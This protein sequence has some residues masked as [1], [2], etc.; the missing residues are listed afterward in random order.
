MHHNPNETRLR[1][2]HGVLSGDHGAFNYLYRYECLYNAPSIAVV[3]VVSLNVALR[4]Q[5]LT[6]QLL[7]TLYRWSVRHMLVEFLAILLLTYLQFADRNL[8]LWALSAAVV[9]FVGASIPT[10]CLSNATGWRVNFAIQ[11]LVSIVRVIVLFYVIYALS[12]SLPETDVTGVRICLLAVVIL[13]TCSLVPLFNISERRRWLLSMR[14][15]DENLRS[16]KFNANKARE[17]NTEIHKMQLTTTG[18]AIKG[19]M[20]CHDSCYMRYSLQGFVCVCVSD[21]LFIY[22][23]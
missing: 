7:S 2:F 4:N 8:T 16:S 14:P 13:S 19:T 12:V 10:C 5:S 9:S 11:I 15:I 20:F 17:V 18:D 1:F 21:I 6:V 3:F 23:A 22:L